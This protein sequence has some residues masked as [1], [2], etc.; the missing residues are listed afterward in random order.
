MAAG[1]SQHAFVEVFDFITRVSSRSAVIR[2]QTYLPAPGGGADVHADTD[3]MPAG[4][5]ADRSMSLTADFPPPSLVVLFQRRPL[6]PSLPRSVDNNR[7]KIIA[8][9]HA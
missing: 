4:R 1:F 2:A 7:G 5:L 9:I 3:Y 6:P 8:N